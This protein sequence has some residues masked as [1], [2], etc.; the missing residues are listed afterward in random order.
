MAEQERQTT[1]IDPTKLNY[2]GR[3]VDCREPRK[4]WL[5]TL[6]TLRTDKIRDLAPNNGNI[7]ENQIKNSET[8]SSNET[9]ESKK[10]IQGSAK[11]PLCKGPNLGLELKVK[12]DT[13]T[14]TKSRTESRST[15]IVT[16]CKDTSQDP[17]IISRDGKPPIHYTKYEI[18]L[19]QFILEHIKTMQ[20]E[21]SFE[22]EEQTCLGKTVDDLEGNDPVARLEDYLQHAKS[23]KVEICQQIRQ[24]LANI[25]CSFINKE[26][27]YTHYVR[28]ITLGAILQES[29]ESQD[30]NCDISGGAQ[31]SMP[32]VTD[33]SVQGSY[34]VVNNS[35]ITRN[36][37]RGHIDSDSGNVTVEEVIEAS[38]EPVSS[39]INKKSRELR[40]IMEWL[41]QC[42][43]HTNQGKV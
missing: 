43:S 27:P 11:V 35:V 2:L 38:M 37:S 25:C 15:K 40:I 22:G 6:D 21:S 12:R 1:E 32:D 18:E 13:S 31:A 30:S 4:T 23:L 39:L 29:Y 7:E 3:G 24:T 19:S 20:T 26:K 36:E 17:N 34:Q 41:L 14:T 5:E 9:T 28:S 16:M 8:V 42:Y 10:G 33:G